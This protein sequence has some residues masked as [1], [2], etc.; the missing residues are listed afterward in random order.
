MSFYN[1]TDLALIKNR[2]SPDKKIGKCLMGF[3]YMKRAGHTRY[4][5]T[6]RFLVFEIKFQFCKCLKIS[7]ISKTLL[8]KTMSEFPLQ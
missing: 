1:Q 3:T 6:G 5:T 2:H 7:K 8:V 4:Q